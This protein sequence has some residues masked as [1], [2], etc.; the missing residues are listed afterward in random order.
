VQQGVPP[1][2]LVEL[3]QLLGRRQLAVDQQVADLEEARPLREL[4]DRVP[5]ISQDPGVTVDVG[6]RGRGR[7][8]VAEAVVVGDVAGRG[9][10]LAHVEAVGSLRC[11]NDTQGQFSTGVAQ[12][13]ICLAH[14][15]R[16]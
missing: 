3:L 7:R 4:V 8:G 1:D 15:R 13:Y 6:D 9:Q 14:R 2:A 12:G 16:R 5:A 10:Q 11:R